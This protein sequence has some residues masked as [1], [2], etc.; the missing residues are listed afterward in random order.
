MLTILFT[1]ELLFAWDGCIRRFCP[2]LFKFLPFDPPPPPPPP[3]PTPDVVE[4]LLFVLYT[5]E[6]RCWLFVELV[7]VVDI[8]VILPSVIVVDEPLLSDRWSK[9]CDAK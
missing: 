5:G 7:D 8:D 6:R 3:P 1:Y 2:L 9:Q 4:L